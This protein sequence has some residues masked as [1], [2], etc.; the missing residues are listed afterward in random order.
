[1]LMNNNP[2]LYCERQSGD[3]CRLHSINAFFGYNKFSTNQFFDLCEEY[4]KHIPGLI[5]KN[6]DGF[7]E[8]RSI[9]SYI[10]NKYTKKFVFLIPIKCDQLS[11][12]YRNQYD[13]D[14]LTKFIGKKIVYY[15]EFNRGHIWLN[16]YYNNKLYKIDSLSGVNHI[17]IPHRFSNN[18]YLIVFEKSL[19]INELQYYLNMIYSTYILKTKNSN[20]NY[21]NLDYETTFQNMYYILKFI[22]LK[23]VSNDTNYNEKVTNLRKI[24][25]LLNNY[26]LL[27]RKNN[28]KN[29]QVIYLEIIKW[30][31]LFYS[32]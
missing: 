31:E 30:I 17:N 19:M 23:Y 18:G 8:G 27:N 10:V 21:N 13:I 25:L 1:M 16:K 11:E 5:S 28:K 26:I 9:I 3:L 32:L 29:I 2:N 7:A 4:D 24:K 20:E 14:R 6:M 22:D 15:F 12:R